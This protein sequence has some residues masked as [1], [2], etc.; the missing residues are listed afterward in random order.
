MKRVC[1]M[2]LVAMLCIST[3][4]ALAACKVTTESSNDVSV[5][6]RE[7]SL[8]LL[9]DFLKGALENPNMVITVKE[10]NTLSFTQ[11][12][13][14]KAS[15]VVF[16]DENTPDAYAFTQGDEYIATYKN[17]GTYSVDKNEYDYTYRMFLM[18]T[19]I[20]YYLENEVSGSYSCTVKAEKKENETTSTLTFKVVTDEGTLKIDASAKNGKVQTLTA[21]T[22]YQGEEPVTYDLSFVYG[23]ARVNV[24][25]ISNWEIEE[26]ENDEYENDFISIANSAKN[27]TTAINFWY[28]AE[29]G[30]PVN[31]FA[32]NGEACTLGYGISVYVLGVVIESGNAL[33]VPTDDNIHVYC[34]TATPLNAATNVKVWVATAEEYVLITFDVIN[35][36]CTSFNVGAPVQ[37]K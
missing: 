24:P 16:S 28:G 7:D 14:G 30:T 34:S 19:G 15:C 20:D 10:G 31:A 25:D 6:N 12:I 22:A 11:S 13:L 21:V 1:I 9:G 27:I 35:G 18:S 36:E 37:Q 23:S 4:F 33:E 8:E 17:A 2:V 5:S 32:L 26:N 29:F 3:V